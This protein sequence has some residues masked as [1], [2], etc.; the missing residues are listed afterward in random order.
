MAQQLINIGN[1]ADDKTGDPIRTA[2]DKVNDNFTEVYG[3]SVNTGWFQVTDQT[4]TSGSPQTFT[5]GV[6]AKLDINVDASITSSIPVG[7]TLSTFYNSTTKRLYGENSGDS[8]LFRLQWVMAPSASNINYL[9]LEL[10]IGG[11]QGAIFQRTATFPKGTSPS[12]YSTTNLY[13]TLGTF[14][15]NGG[16]F[17]V[18][19]DGANVD[20]YDI[21]LLVSRLHKAGDGS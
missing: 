19:A 3:Q 20:I 8:Y 2:F 1:A 4:Y 12:S 5:N 15:A 10:D 6:R 11:S 7:T 9:D 13:Y 14:Q 16:E 17:Y 21:T 18:T